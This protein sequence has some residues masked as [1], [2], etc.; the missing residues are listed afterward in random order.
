[1]KNDFLTQTLAPHKNHIKISKIIMKCYLSNAHT[2]C[3]ISSIYFFHQIF[4]QSEIQRHFYIHTPF[5]L[6]FQIWPFWPL[7]PKNLN[8][9]NSFL[10]H[11]PQ[12]KM[13][14][15]SPK[16]LKSI[17]VLTMKLLYTYFWKTLPIG[18]LICLA[19][20]WFIWAHIMQPTSNHLKITLFSKPN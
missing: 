4:V 6:H 5:F 15:K 18:A 20:I 1:M 14:Q 16:D 2:I 11:Y 8:L 3:Y 13:N 10:A 19:R 7:K 12:P 9:T 17:L